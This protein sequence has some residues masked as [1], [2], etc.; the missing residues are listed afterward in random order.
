LKR[1]QAQFDPESIEGQKRLANIKVSIL[2]NNF[3]IAYIKKWLN[4]SVKN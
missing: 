1:I 3:D 4:T 2:E